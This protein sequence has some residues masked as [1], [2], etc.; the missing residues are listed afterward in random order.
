MWKLLSG[1]TRLTGV[2]KSL[3]RGKL[4]R[5]FHLQ[6]LQIADEINSGGDNWGVESDNQANQ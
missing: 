3:E 4:F 5:G 1:V 2:I 6:N